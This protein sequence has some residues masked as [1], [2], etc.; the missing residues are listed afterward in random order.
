MSD[1][2]SQPPYIYQVKIE[3][4]LGSQW[5]DWF[6]GMSI[7]HEEENITVLTGAIV[8]QSAL[9]GLLKKL[10]NLGMTLISLQRLDEG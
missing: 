10:R 4:Y 5:V 7:T 9:Y 6:D 3:G 8:D 2:H 1:K